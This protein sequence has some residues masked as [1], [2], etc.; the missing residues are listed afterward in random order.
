MHRSPED[1][2][3]QFIEAFA[4][5]DR[6]A[7]EGCLDG[8]VRFESPMMTLTGRQAVLD[9]IIGFAEAVESVDVLAV[10]GGDDKAMIMYDMH[11]GPFGTVRAVDYVVVRDGTITSDLLV[12]DTHAVRAASNQ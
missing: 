11:T 12:F 1:V 5:R 6:S 7:V 8:D 4:R 10:V 2:V 9:A 3:T